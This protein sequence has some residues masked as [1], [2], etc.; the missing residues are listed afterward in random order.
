M[1]HL[2]RSYLKDPNLIHWLFRLPQ[3]SQRGLTPAALSG[4]S[5]RLRC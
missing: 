2:F 3:A 5:G 1:A 4:A